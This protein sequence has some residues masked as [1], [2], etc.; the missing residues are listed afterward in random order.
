MRFDDSL[1]T[2]LSA[3]ATTGFGA[4]SAWRQLVD[5]AGRRRIADIDAAIARLGML[6]GSVP[7]AVRAASGRALAF[8]NP[9]ALLVGFFAEDD[10]AIAAPVL[11]TA[12]LA[13]DDWVALLP[14]LSPAGRS[15]LRHRRDL[16][17]PVVRALESFGSTDFV[18]HHQPGADASVAPAAAP[19]V[20]PPI[21]A[22]DA[23]P[24]R[25][26]APLSETPFVPLGTV[27]RGLPVVAEAL[28]RHEAGSPPTPGAN[29]F[30]ISD[31]VARIDAFNRTRPEP[32]EAAPVVSPPA[33]GFRFETDAAGVIR[34]VEGG[35]RA[36]LVGVGLARASSYGPVR[37]DATAGGALRRRAD[38]DDA[39]LE[40]DG[41][42]DAAGSWRLSGTATFEPRTGRFSGF[43]GV[44][45]RPRRDQSATPPVPVPAGGADS[46]RQLVHELRTPTN[47]IA[48]FA[49]LIGSELLG[50]V[51]P[52]YRERAQSIH[53]QATDLIGAIEDLDTAARIESGALELRP[54]TIDLVP[55]I[56]R[57]VADLAPL[58]AIRGVALAVEP[59]TQP[60]QIVGDDRAVERLLSRLAAALVAAGG[61]G[62]RIGVTMLADPPVVAIRFDRPHALRV[63]D[64]AALL[65]LDGDGDAAGAPLLGTGFALRLARNLA[66]EL[67]GGLSIAADG[68][69]LRLPMAVD[70]SVGQASIN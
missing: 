28:R 67:G 21:P 48:G 1:K 38:F 53:A 14:R 36:A 27:T 15:V 7:V 59:V 6:R 51:S 29:G 5:L 2:I 43:R 57:I 12:T 24:V 23:V 65:S 39:R 68:L 35:G 20:A 37:I 55:L 69:T 11:R 41:Q 50:P 58:A 10:L 4:Q 63:A 33:E 31:L 62:E 16:P 42:S 32:G 56:A 61:N 34:W 40:V 13:A 22:N 46:L 44:G 64:D 9:P 49:E 17:A 70:R 45:R 47:A 52:A 25:P 60:L 19:V 26:D 30:V 54:T 3:D 66:A 18:I 8:A